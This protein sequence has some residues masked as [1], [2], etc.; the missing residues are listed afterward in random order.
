VQRGRGE[1]GPRRLPRE[2]HDNPTGM[3][4]A[5]FRQQFECQLVAEAQSNRA[6][7]HAYAHPTAAQCLRER[8]EMVGDLIGAAPHLG[9]DAWTGACLRAMM[10]MQG[11]VALLV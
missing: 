7:S 9:H 2:Q 4:I 6:I 11:M 8:A 10:V 3:V 5:G 1:A